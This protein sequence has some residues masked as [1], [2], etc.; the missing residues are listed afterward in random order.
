[1]TTND[2]QTAHEGEKNSFEKGFEKLFS[3]FGAFIKEHTTSSILLLLATFAALVIA[4]SSYAQD[5]EQL[6]KTPFGFMLGDASS[7]MSL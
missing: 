2:N 6:F 1:M 7:E 3:P 5:Y 4:N